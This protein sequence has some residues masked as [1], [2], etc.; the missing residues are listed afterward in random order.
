[1]QALL[2]ASV[3]FL[4]DGFF[5]KFVPHEI[6]LYLDAGGE[7]RY[8]GYTDLPAAEFVN[9]FSLWF[10]LGIVQAGL[11]HFSTFY[12]T[13]LREHCPCPEYPFTDAFYMLVFGTTDCFIGPLLFNGQ[14]GEERVEHV[15]TSTG[16]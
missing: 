1:M 15:A 2:Q 16:P 4:P 7:W 5:G 11:H 3:P 6:Y 8:D 13:S 12:V 10:L 9:V 14:G